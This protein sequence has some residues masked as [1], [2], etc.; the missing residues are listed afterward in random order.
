MNQIKNIATI[1]RIIAVLLMV[2]SG[3]WFVLSWWFGPDQFSIQLSCPGCLGNV[4]LIHA[5]LSAGRRWVGF[6]IMLLPTVLLVCS[7]GRLYA[8]FTHISSGRAYFKSTVHSLRGIAWYFF[9]TSVT[10]IVCQSVLSIWLTWPRGVGHRL[11]LLSI[12]DSHL[13]F[14]IM[15]VFSLVLSYVIREGVSLREQSDLIV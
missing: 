11:M 13:L 10:T 9:W 2:F 6:S 12:G 4:D 5:P 14:F 3:I 7:Y 15:T 8:L 1:G